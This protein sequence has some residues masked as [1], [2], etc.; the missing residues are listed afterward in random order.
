MDDDRTIQLRD[1]GHTVLVALDPQGPYGD[2]LTTTVRNG[3]DFEVVIVSAKPTELAPLGFANQFGFDT[4]DDTWIDQR[5]RID[6][7]VDDACQILGDQGVP[8]RVVEAEYRNSF[9]EGWARR[10][11]ARSIARVGDEVEAE[12]IVVGDSDRHEPS[13]DALV[14]R[15]SN[16]PVGRALSAYKPAADLNRQSPSHEQPDLQIAV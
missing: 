11:L 3:C 13:L 5:R 14:R 8:H 15:H 12:F 16:L 7:Q 9:F 2:F 4:W 6:R 10:N 1:Y